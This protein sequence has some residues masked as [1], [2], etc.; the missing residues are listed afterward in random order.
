MTH[1]PYRTGITTIKAL[2]KKVCDLL[3]RY[4]AIIK[5]ILPPSQHVYVDALLQACTDFQDNVDNPRPD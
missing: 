2:L 3:V 4:S 5:Q 1:I